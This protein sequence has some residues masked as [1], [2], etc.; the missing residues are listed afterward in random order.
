MTD[1]TYAAVFRRVAVTT[2]LGGLS[3]EDVQIFL[4]SFI[5]DFVPGCPSDELRR[6]AIEFT[7]EGGPWGRGGVY[8]PVS[9]ES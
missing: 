8:P 5:S 3:A 4:S 9:A 7:G 2:S 6:W 1:P